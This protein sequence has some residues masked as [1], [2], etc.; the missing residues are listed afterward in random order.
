MEQRARVSGGEFE[1]KLLLNTL[2]SD[3]GCLF[4]ELAPHS[5]EDG[6]IDGVDARE[7]RVGSKESIWANRFVGQQGFEEQDRLVNAAKRDVESTQ[8]GEWVLVGEGVERGGATGRTLRHEV[9]Q[10]RLIGGM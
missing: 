8:V 5:G 1:M 4:P 10:Q 3:Q 2:R 6:R 7:L 9:S